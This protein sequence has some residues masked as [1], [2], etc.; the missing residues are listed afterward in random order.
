MCEIDYSRLCRVV[1]VQTL[2]VPRVAVVACYLLNLGKVVVGGG[3]GFDEDL[4][5]SSFRKLKSKF[6]LKHV[7]R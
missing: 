4:N 3:G 1:Q 6:A 2:C 7:A 5:K